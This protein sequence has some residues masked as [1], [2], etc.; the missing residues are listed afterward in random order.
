VIKFVCKYL[1]LYCS[2]VFAIMY[3]D[4]MGVNLI[5]LLL[6]KI[7]EMVPRKNGCEESYTYIVL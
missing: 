1:N 2:I 6:Y 5:L 3:Q 4:R 7:L